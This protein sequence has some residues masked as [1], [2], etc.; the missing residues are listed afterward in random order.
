MLTLLLTASLAL[1]KP[2]ASS[3][4]EDGDGKHGA[5][6]ALDGLLSTGWAEGG[7]GH[8]AGAWWEFDLASPTKLEVISLWPG[9]LKEGRK[10]FREYARPKTV[11]IY[12]DGAQVGEP[13]RVQDEMKRVDVP[14][15][16]TGKKVRVEVVEVYEGFVY[17]DCHLAEV[18]VNLTE[19]ERAR[20]VEKV[21]AWRGSKEA[22]KLLA[23]HEEEVV[24]AFR[25]HKE[26]EDEDEGLAFLMSTAADGPLYLRKKV[27]SL[28]PEGY[29]VAAIVPDPKAMDALR[30]LKDPNGIPGLEMAALRSIGKQQREINEVVEQFYAYQEMVGARRN[31][32]AWGETG[33]EP[34]ALRAFGEPLAVEIDRMGQIYVADTGNNR[35]Q[36]FNQDGL[37]ERSWGPQPD[38]AEAWFG[39]TRKW[40]ASGAAPGDKNGEFHNPVDIELIPVKDGDQF[41]VLDA[42]NRIQIFDEAG[43]PLIG[44][45]VNVDEEMEPRVGGE[46]YLAW[47]PQKKQIVAFIGND[48]VAYTLDSEEV[49][50]WKV[51]DG[52]PNACEVGKDGRIYL[53][54]GDEIVAYNPDGFRYGTVI[55]AKILGEGFEDL[56]ITLDEEQRMWV[57]TDRGWAFLFKK[58]GKLDWKVKVSDV[59]LEHPRFAVSQGLV[60]VTDRDRIVKTDALQLHTDELEALEAKAEQEKAEK[61]TKGAGSK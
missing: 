24:E 36:R 12:V 29:R 30:K 43:A 5:D 18:A 48:A 50:R 57:L 35:V 40:Y 33:F 7:I 58:P 22:E 16:V 53:A 56:D 13:V 49:G 59:E 11:K 4:A 61:A 47:V 42:H 26:D 14:V 9:N 8:G 19:G 45:A 55:D 23:K 27:G 6:L 10:S 32:K 52:T 31:I 46:G 41:A 37:A 2:A 60:F 17:A 20:A 25:K 44:W 51:K 21:E 39:K 54:F 3:I 38:I 28:V 34:G 1:A 15:D